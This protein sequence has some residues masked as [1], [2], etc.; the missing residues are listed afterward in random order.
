MNIRRHVGKKKKID[1]SLAKRKNIRKKKLFGASLV[2][3]TKVVLYSTKRQNCLAKILL[4]NYSTQRCSYK[5]I[6]MFRYAG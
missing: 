2:Y 6:E 3:L 1:F 5:L 4:T